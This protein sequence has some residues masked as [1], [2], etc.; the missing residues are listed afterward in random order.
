MICCVS[1]ALMVEV[2]IK[3]RPKVI[4]LSRKDG[5]AETLTEAR[6]NCK[7]EEKVRGI[8]PF[9]MMGEV[10]HSKETFQ[11]NPEM[12]VRCL[13]ESSAVSVIY[14]HFGQCKMYTQVGYY[15]YYVV[16]IVE[17]IVYNTFIKEFVILYFRTF[18]CT[19]FCSNTQG[20]PWC[21]PTVRTVCAAWCQ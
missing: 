20:V 21:L 4:D 11:Y 15:V 6:I 12:L 9:C 19:I 5:M 2:G 7:L 8:V 18:T 13:L 14:L 3:E 10:I 16:I 17:L 1:D